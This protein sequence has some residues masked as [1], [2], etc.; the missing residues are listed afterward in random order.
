MWLSAAEFLASGCMSTFWNVLTGALPPQLSPGDL[1]AAKT[2]CSRGPKWLFAQG[3]GN[4]TLLCTVQ[5]RHLA[6]SRP[7]TKKVSQKVHALLARAGLATGSS[8]VPD[9]A[10]VCG[11][12]ASQGWSAASEMSFNYRRR[13]AIT[14]G[15]S[16]QM[17]A[18]LLGL[19]SRLP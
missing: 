12:V 3:P 18:P 4:R 14:P 15:L 2:G 10:G 6:F 11:S 9:G 5:H 1:S 13:K 19:T 16:L 8:T 17:A 7:A